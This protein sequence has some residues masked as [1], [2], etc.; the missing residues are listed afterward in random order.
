MARPKEFSRETALQ[1][2]VAVFSD[3][4]F[5]GTSTDALLSAMGISR[6]SMY[7]TF[8]GKWRL[9]LE[10]L[11]RYTADSVGEQLRV[12]NAAP[13]PMKGIADMLDY[14][15]GKATENPSVSC[16]GVSAVCEFGREKVEIAM[17][18]DTAHMTL[19]SSLERRI[20]EAK[21]AGRIKADVDPREAANFLVA[22][23]MS[24][25]V[26]ARGGA[27]SETLHGIT[28]MALRSLT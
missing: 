26:S 21:A 27:T 10:A 15:I 17:L 18:T 16:L 5:E 9:Y 14:M 28:R 6:Q 19:V 8:G 7:D 24:I 3:H 20:G 1:T 23:L 11:Q 25:R 4:G 13:D 22:T 2:A 12:L